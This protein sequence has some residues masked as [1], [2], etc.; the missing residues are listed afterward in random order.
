MRLNWII[1]FLALFSGTGIGQSLFRVRALKLSEG[2]SFFRNYASLGIGPEIKSRVRKRDQFPA[3]PCNWSAAQTHRG[4]LSYAFRLHDRFAG[5]LGDGIANGTEFVRSH[6]FN[7]N[8]VFHRCHF[9]KEPAEA[10]PLC[11]LTTPN[12]SIRDYFECP[13]RWTQS[14]LRQ[15]L[16]RSARVRRQGLGVLSNTE[17]SANDKN[18]KLE[19]SWHA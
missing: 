4:I 9:A 19:L 8:T 18:G 17:R 6:V 3:V 7:E 1:M 5:S 16:Y 14:E 12:H 10:G 13:R 11:A 15:A 2:Q